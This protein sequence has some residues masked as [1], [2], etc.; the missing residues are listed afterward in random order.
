MINA[1]INKHLPRAFD[2]QLKDAVTAFTGTRK[3]TGGAYDPELGE[4][5]DAADI[6]YAG[7]GT[8]GRFKN[9]EI[10]ATQIEVTDTRL[11]C[12]HI[13][14]DIEPD[15]DDIITA[16]GVSRRVMTVENSITDNEWVIQLRGLNVG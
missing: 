7:R 4:Y 14:V 9:E 11:F 12:L 5:I 15:I 10:Q 13:E 16:N 8:F 6:N 1:L 2:N 3:V